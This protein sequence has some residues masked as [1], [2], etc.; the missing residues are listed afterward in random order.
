MEEVII[1]IDEQRKTIST[2]STSLSSQLPQNF[3]GD[4]KRYETP[5]ELYLKRTTNKGNFDPPS[6]KVSKWERKIYDKDI[7]QERREFLVHPAY[8]H[9]YQVK[10]VRITLTG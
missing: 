7:V 9:H 6:I 1:L 10:S 8:F 3:H 2:K 4:I 5:T